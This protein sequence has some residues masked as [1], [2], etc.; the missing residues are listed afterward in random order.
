MRE[1]YWK[2]LD[3]RYALAEGDHEKALQRVNEVIE[4]FRHQ[5]PILYF[6]KDNFADD[7]RLGREYDPDKFNPYEVAD[8]CNEVYQRHSDQEYWEIL[9]DILAD[10]YSHYEVTHDEPLA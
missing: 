10:R 1:F 2:L 8:I 5:T 9:G 3:A 7:Y 4:H 6:S